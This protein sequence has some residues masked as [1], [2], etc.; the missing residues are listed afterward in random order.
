MKW[1]I[2]KLLLAATAILG[3][4]ILPASAD[5]LYSE[6]FNDSSADVTILQQPDTTTGFVNYGNMTVGSTNFSIPESPRM[7]AGSAPTRGILLRANS[8]DATPRAAAV[9]VLA[10]N[11]PLRFDGDFCLSY[12]MYLSVSPITE[13]VDPTT[14][15]ISYSL[16]AGSTEQGLWG[17]GVGD[18]IVEARNTR[19]SGTMGTWGW[20]DG[21]NGY[22]F[23]DA[24]IW[25]DGTNLDQLGDTQLFQSEFFNA[26][27][28]AP[29]APDAPNN[30]AGNA[31]VEVDVIVQGGEVAVFY[32]GVEFFREASSATV[33]SV[34][35]GY[36]DPFSSITDSPDG[37]WGLFDNFVVKEIVPEPNA[38]LLAMVLALPLLAARRRR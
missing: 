3:A 29:I 33:G 4:C 36:E 14:G 12:D 25:E 17:V 35:F 9:N 27:F 34:M 13:T 24:S 10:G 19:F 20:V 7:I 2:S 21:D 11:V 32:N 23:E 1:T 16:P 28:P 30:A 18:S 6:A 31:W 38:G 22:G 37:M 5:I 15:E 8:D 26:A